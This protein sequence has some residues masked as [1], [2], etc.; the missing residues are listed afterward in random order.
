MIKAEFF[1]ENGFLL[2]FKIFGHS[3]YAEQSKDIVCASVS[4]AT[5]LAVNIITE[6]K[7]IKANVKADEK[8]AQIS[9][10]LKDNS[11]KEFC[12]LI[13]KGLVF[14]LEFIEEDYKDYIH[15]EITEV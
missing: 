5:Q 1:R 15:L 3:G 4:S 7:H 13:L 8:N 9:F 6:I 14:Q 12:D 10:Y 11:N 2:G